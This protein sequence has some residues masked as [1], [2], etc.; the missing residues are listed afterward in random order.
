VDRT[1]V[2]LAL[3]TVPS[4]QNMQVGFVFREQPELASEYAD[5]FDQ[6]LMPGTRS[7]DEWLKAHG[8]G[9]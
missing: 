3:N 5:W 2:L 8:S 7:F 4:A 1:H 9:R 6:V